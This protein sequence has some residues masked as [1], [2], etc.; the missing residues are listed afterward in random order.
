MAIE[1]EVASSESTGINLTPLIDII[2]QLLIFFLLSSTF[3]VPALEMRLPEI[4]NEK[5]P[6]NSSHII[7]SVDEGRNIFLNRQEVTLD[8]LQA[9]LQDV[10]S[11]QDEKTVFFRGDRNLPYEQFLE[12]MDLSRKAG[13][14]DFNLLHQPAD[15]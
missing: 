2:F 4:S 8:S 1:F 6:E 12:L 9:E 11:R 10:L 13:A 3:M 5:L 14:S 7:I 15:P